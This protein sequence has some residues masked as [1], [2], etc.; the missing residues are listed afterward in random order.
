MIG[1]KVRYAGL[2]AYPVVGLAEARRR[3]DRNRALISAGI[4]PLAVA[5]PPPKPTIAPT[6]REAA[7]AYITN[8]QPEWANA[9]HGAQW[10]STLVT[11]VYETIGDMPVNTIKRA[12]VL[13]V[14]K[15]IWRGKTETAKRVRSRIEV[16]LDAAHAKDGEHWPTWAN[17]STWKTLRHDLPSPAAIAPVK[18]FV[19]VPYVDAPAVMARLRTSNGIGALAL[20][21]VV[22]T[23]ARTQMTIGARWDE[24]TGSI[25]TIPKVRANNEASGLKGGDSMRVPLSAEAV[26]IL[27]QMRA[28]RAEDHPYVFPG[29]IDGCGI[30]NATMALALRTV[31]PSATVHGWRSTFRDWVGEET[32]HPA[33]VAEAALNHKLGNKTRLAYQRGQLF[34][35]RIA[36][37][38]DWANYLAA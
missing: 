8:H 26:N 4:D 2:G 18:H 29:L 10:T 34:A 12:D 3:R 14:L 11:Y 27:D 38:D 23:A 37:M 13:N 19:A 7:E 35:K 6:F 33:D 32:G 16:I 31:A 28:G 24:I 21:F 36:M 22:L 5:V 17:P 15:P 30:S 25:W 9:K 20:R 1:G